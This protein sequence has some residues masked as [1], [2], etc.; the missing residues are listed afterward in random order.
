MNRAL[1]ALVAGLGALMP[2][3][4]DS[5]LKGVVLLAVAALCALLLWRALAATRHLAW[6]VAVVALLVLPLLSAALPQWRVLPHW[7]KSVRPAPTT[8][9]AQVSDASHATYRTYAPQPVSGGMPPETVEPPP[10][11][12]IHSYTAADAPPAASHVPAPTLRDWLPLAWA[13]G[14]A[15]LVIRLIAAHIFLCRAAR[16][17]VALSN[18]NADAIT[19]AFAAACSQLGIR[20]RITV[21]IDETR[22]IPVVWGIFQ[23]RLLL[24]A[25]ALQLAD[26]ATGEP[27]AFVSAAPF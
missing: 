16:G 13:A 25:T 24:P 6:L 21:L 20:Q 22:A 11:L 14:C 3:V 19:T 17:C 26:P 9:P 15:L 7:T 1:L 4:L 5:A 2:L 12:Q 18:A 23:P 10:A 8:P 27:L